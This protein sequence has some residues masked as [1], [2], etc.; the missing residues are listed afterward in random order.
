MKIV[1][2]ID[3]VNFIL[4]F[5]GDDSYDIL[6]EI[7]KLDGSTFNVNNK[8]WKVIPTKTNIERLGKLGFDFT[9]RTFSIIGREK[10]KR[11]IDIVFMNKT[12]KLLADE[13]FL[14]ELSDHF[15]CWDYSEAYRG[16]KFNKKRIKEVRFL[17]IRKGV[18]LLPI[19]FF[20][21]LEDYL[22]EF[23]CG[24][25]IKD[26]R[27]FP[28][29]NFTD[30]E[31]RF[32][33]DYLELYDY[34]VV[35]VKRCLSRK[36]GIIKLP[37]G[38]GKTEIFL[39]LC[40]LMKLK[41][42]ILFSR[43]DLARQTLDRGI[44]AGLDTGIIQGNKVDEDHDIVNCTIQSSGKL[45]NKYDV[46]IV[47][48]VHNAKGG[49]YQEFLR[50]KNFLYRFGFSATPFAD[51]AK[52]KLG[53][54]KVK[55]YIG[56]IIYELPS[57]FLISEEKIAKPKI[58]FIKIGGTIEGDNWFEIE[59]RGIVNNTGRNERIAGACKKR[60]KT[61]ILIKKI[62][63]GHILESLIPNSIFLSG[64]TDS[65]IKDKFIGEFER[66]DDIVIIASTIFD[67]G[68]NIKSIRNLIVA[69]GGRSQRKVIQRIG[70]GMRI[71]EGKTSVNV[72]D[73]YDE[74]NEIL[75]NH[76]EERIK[77]YEKEGFEDIKIV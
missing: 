46:V 43:V 27:K 33:L 69:G 3:G 40:K 74:Q 42:L 26:N 11:N 67:E 68:I 52:N 21:D 15:K 47:D 24:Y 37:T 76:S 65:E 49:R 51:G 5:K 70:R 23:N 55:Q 25:K 20:D 39:A 30:E 36:N 63:H 34:Q 71:S 6:K 77:F 66:G 12:L 64:E 60:K 16:G 31:V 9:E 8:T 58:I 4:R 73:F 13:V 48:E 32:C 19:G 41:V 53:N 29:Y 1:D 75:C 44:K 18:G 2:T 72:Y 61:V 62:I 35:A 10:E 54:Y 56:D 45:R 59:D 57:N 28:E 38:S 7:K 17:N 22:Y 50:K 14:Y